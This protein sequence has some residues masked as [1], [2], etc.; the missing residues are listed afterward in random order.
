M[1]VKIP[2]YST[3]TG[4]PETILR[5]MQTANFT[6]ISPDESAEDYLQCLRRRAEKFFGVRLE[7]TGETYAERAESLLR[8]LAKNNLIELT[9]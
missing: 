4:T 2:G 8:S 5:V 9:D 7:V 1:T 3:L 6:Y